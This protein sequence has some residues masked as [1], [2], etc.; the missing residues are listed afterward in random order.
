[1]NIK[2]D[3]YLSLHEFV[4]AFK[5]NIQKLENLDESP[6]DLWYPVMFIVVYK[7]KWPTWSE[8]HRSTLRNLDEDPVRMLTILIDNL[9]DEARQVSKTKKSSGSSALPAGN[10][11]GGKGSVNKGKSKGNFKEKCPY[12]KHPKPDHD[13]QDCFEKN[14]K[15]RK[16]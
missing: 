12:Y 8:R 3:N 10:S 6:P 4:I 2:Y 13:P 16:E 9:T 5:L 11:K 1:M 7:E 14:N 15:K